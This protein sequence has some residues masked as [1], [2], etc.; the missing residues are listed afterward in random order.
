MNGS[1][2]TGLGIVGCGYIADSYAA[3][4][5][6]HADALA[7]VCVHDR[8]PERQD[9]YSRFWGFRAAPDLDALLGDPGVEIVVNLTDPENHEAVTLRA[10]AAG[11]HVYSEKPLAMTAAG[12]ERVAQAAREAGLRL[13]GAPCN[14]LGEHVQTLWRAVR[15]G[16]AGPIRLIYAEMDDG[17]VHRAP[18][19]DWSNRSGAPWPARGEFEVGCTFEH[20]GYTLT[21]LVAMFGPVRRVTAFAHLCMPDKAT[22]P[23]LPHPAPDM[24]VACLEFDGGVVARMTNSVVAPYDHRLRLIGEGGVLSVAE[25]WRY[26]SP[27]RF[28]PTPT[29]RIGRLLERRL[30]YTPARTLAPARRPPFRP[31]RGMPAMDFMRGVR[32]LADAIRE[33]RPC[34][35]SP[36]LAVHVSEVTEAAQHPERFALPHAVRSSAPPIEPMPW[37]L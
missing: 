31:G 24:S 19:R 26:D 33:D 16:V 11:K 37:G 28:A 20:A 22:D 34:R 15:A 25:P 17:M 4:A 35:L 36:E 30:G 27:V 5:R 8:R 32:E 7:I 6:L 13:A 29:T 18:Y 1:P 12:A 3:A 2:P 9:A 14:L 23:P 21:A 10:L